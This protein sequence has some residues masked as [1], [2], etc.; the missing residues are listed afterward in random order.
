[1]AF[2]AAAAAAAAATVAVAAESAVVVVVVRVV[3]VGTKAFPESLL[4]FFKGGPSLTCRL[5]SNLLHSLYN[6][7]FSYHSG[8]CF[9][10]G[11]FKV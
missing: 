6:N 11:R 2:T 10:Y 8:L 3:M 7:L 1:M 9:I 5:K 4:S